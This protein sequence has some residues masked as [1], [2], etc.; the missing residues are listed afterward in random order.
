[1][2]SHRYTHTQSNTHIHTHTRVY[3]LT[4]THTHTHSHTHTNTQTHTHSQ[5]TPTNNLVKVFKKFCNGIFGTPDQNLGFFSYAFQIF[6]E[7]LI[8]AYAFLKNHDSSM[9][10]FKSK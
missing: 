10:I 5:G 2:H 6:K 8:L 3:T 1:M 7:W 4:H 9:S